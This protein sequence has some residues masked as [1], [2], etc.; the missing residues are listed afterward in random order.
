M[1]KIL[2]VVGILTGACIVSFLLIGVF[3]AR[4]DYKIAFE[5][6]KP[7]DQTFKSFT[8]ATLMGD[9]MTGFKRMETL[10]GKPGEVGSKYRLVF[11]EG[12]KDVIVDEEVIALKENE[13]F[14]FSMDNDFLS[15]T[16]EF[17]FTENN[18]KTTVTYINDTAGKNIIYKSILALFRSDIMERNKK[19][20][21]KLKTIIESKN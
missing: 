15:G 6:N 19:D 12:D 1:K 11:A 2:A 7:A 21:E 10:S 14:V 9:W 4:L 18:R 3:M 13:L 17:R 16:G 5:V 20:F 8:D